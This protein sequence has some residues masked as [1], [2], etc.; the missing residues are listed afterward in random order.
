[1]SENSE[2][3]RTAAHEHPGAAPVPAADEQ[4]VEESAVEGDAGQYVEGDYGRAG[5]AGE[6]PASAPEGE[7]PEGDYGK[8]GVAGGSH[9][10]AE[11]GDYPEG[12][13]G[14][15]GATGPDAV[16]GEEGEYPEGDYGTAGAAG[17]RRAGRGAE[18]PADETVGRDGA[19]RDDAGRGDV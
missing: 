17:V 3:D 18:V 14:P 8:A 5:V 7:Y 4:V 6:N 11:A 16:V 10:G 1:M 19:V 13:Y 9:V 12:D 2:F 15:A